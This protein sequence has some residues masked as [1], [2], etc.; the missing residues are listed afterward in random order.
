MICIA[1]LMR[2]W[3]SCQLRTS[4]LQITL[5]RNSVSAKFIEQQDRR[6]NA[7]KMMCL[8]L[9]T[10]APWIKS[11]TW[12]KIGTLCSAKIRQY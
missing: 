12:R 9:Q 2:E 1:T 6:I 7:R 5:P 4:S 8:A 11:T 10:M 3:I